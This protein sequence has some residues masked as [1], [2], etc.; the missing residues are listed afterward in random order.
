M[1]TGVPARSAARRMRSNVVRCESCVPCE[2]FRRK[3]SVPAA[4]RASSMA[5]LSLAGP[6]VAMIL[7]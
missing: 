6:T 2:K 3:I 1:A 4:M 5:S 7:V